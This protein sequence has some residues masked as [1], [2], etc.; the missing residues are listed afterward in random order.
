MGRDDKVT[1]CLLQSGC[2]QITM[3]PLIVPGVHDKSLPEVDHV[4]TITA[5]GIQSPWSLPP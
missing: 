1:H 4:G 2:R 3:S 5:V